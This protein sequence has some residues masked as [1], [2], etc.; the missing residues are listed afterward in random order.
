MRKV[1]L[2]GLDIIHSGNA[3]S[4]RAAPCSRAMIKHLERNEDIVTWVQAMRPHVLACS[5]Y[6]RADG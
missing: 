3:W 1:A 5:G 2:D 4:F 6:T